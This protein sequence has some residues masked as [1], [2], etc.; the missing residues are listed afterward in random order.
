MGTNFYACK[1]VC[2]HCGREES[3]LHIGKSSMGWCFSLHVIP[4]EGINNLGDWKSYLSRDDITI[5]NEYGDTITFEQ[6]LDYIE[7]RRGGDKELGEGEPPFMY[8]SWRQFLE[9][10]NA[11]IGPK[12]LLRH[13]VDG[14]H[15]IGHSNGTFDY[16]AGEFS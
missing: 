10:N 8:T 12:N 6:M 7:N 3:Q 11:K 5:K 2:E 15:C 16:I 14:R 13:V 1:D 9:Q 4:E